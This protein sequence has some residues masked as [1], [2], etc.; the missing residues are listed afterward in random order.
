MRIGSKDL[1]EKYKGSRHKVARALL[2]GKLD[3]SEMDFVEDIISARD[4]QK[5]TAGLLGKTRRFIG[6]ALRRILFRE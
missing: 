4:L 3:E 1:L 2:R 6:G 5:A